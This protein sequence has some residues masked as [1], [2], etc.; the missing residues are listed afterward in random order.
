MYDLDPTSDAAF[1]SFLPGVNVRDDD[2]VVPRFYLGKRL[3][4]FKS[5]QA[6]REIYED[7]E[8]IEMRIKGQSKGIPH[9]MVGP[10][11]I[12]RWP[13][14][15]AAFKVGRELP[16]VGTPI[17]QL[18]GIGPSMVHNLKGIGIRTIEDMAKTSDA[19]L[20][21]IGTGARGLQTSAK[22]FIDKANGEVVELKDQ[23]RQLQ[24]QL[25]ALTASHKKESA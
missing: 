4:G 10:E 24:E 3:M 11:H 1:M 13:N 21:E 9:E 16:V 18:P 14:A 6:G 7:V 8:M 25:A 2:S 5:K 23:V 22:A 20:Q 12:K 17:E 19:V 15:Y